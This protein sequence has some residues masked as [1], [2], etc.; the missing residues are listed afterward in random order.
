MNDLIFGSLST[1][2]LRR[3]RVLEQRRG[4]NHHGRRSP[5]DP[6]P[7][8]SVQLELIAGPDTSV[9]LAWVYWTTDG[10]E[11]GGSQ[12]QAA[13]GFAAPMQTDGAAWDTECWGYLRKFTAT[14]PG[15]PDGTIVRYCLSLQDYTR[16][17]IYADQGAVSAFYTANDPTPSWASA[18]VVYHIFVDRFNPGSG[19]VWESPAHPSGFY[20]GRIRGITEKLDYLQDAG[21]NTLWLSPIFPSPSHHG[22][23]ATDLYSVEPR[24]GS[25]ADLKELLDACHARGMRVLLDF[26]PNHW[27]DEHPA[28]RS[29]LK[30]ENSPYRDWFT[31]TH[32]PDEYNTFFGVKNLPQV[33][34]QNPA[35]REHMLGAALHWLNLG[36][37]GFRLDYALGPAQ[38]FWA[39]FRKQTRA[40]NPECWTFGEVIDPPTD[41]LAFEGLLDGC[42]DFNLLEAMRQTFAYGTWDVPHFAS[43]LERHEAFFPAGFS[44]PSFLDNHDMNRFLWSV[45]G[46]TQK[47]KLAALCQ[48][49]LAGAPIVYYGTEVGLSQ[50]RD[51]RQGEL[52]V[53][54]ES[55]LPMLWGA[56]QNSE[57]L[58]FYQDL[59]SLR[60][61]CPDLSSHERTTLY[62]DDQ[63]LVYRKKSA[64]VVLNIGT[65]EKGYSLPEPELKIGL[66]TAKTCI[67]KDSVIRLE[68]WSGAILM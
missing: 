16:G 19:H 49:S 4:V 45:K 66:S 32:W 58:A 37:D 1:D 44:R 54:E 6:L 11:P 29:A 48:F 60:K 63:L 8:Q 15:Q 38:E 46:D 35:A 56:Q 55:R 21:F 61:A 24:L 25:T 57:L 42:L 26:V 18:A 9:E 3:K 34:L 64:L 28:F 27:S 53:F 33:N 65:A 36:V 2:E 7:M 20:G 13:N 67:V 12:G 41:Q 31:F 52:G 59:I 17:E 40:A 47:L 62:A 39:D 23:D 10:S 43:F 68:G 30:D 50:E 22:Y 5:R 14:L 51:I